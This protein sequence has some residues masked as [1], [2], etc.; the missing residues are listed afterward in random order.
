MSSTYRRAF[1][2]YKVPGTDY[3]AV[4]ASHCYFQITLGTAIVI[5]PFRDPFVLAK[6]ISTLGVASKDRFVFGAW[7]GRFEREY[8][9]QGKNWNGRIQNST[10]KSV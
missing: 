4:D 10:K 6:E 3:Y 2:R 9:S 5:L 1:Y 7:P 8:L